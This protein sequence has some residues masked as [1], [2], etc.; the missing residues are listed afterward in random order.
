MRFRISVRSAV[1]QFLDAWNT[2]SIQRTP[3][4]CFIYIDC[5]TTPPIIARSLTDGAYIMDKKLASER[6]RALASND[7][8]RSKAARLRDVIDDVEAVLAAGVTRADVVAELGALGLEM[9]LATF[10][11]TLK[12]LRQ[13]R[14]K[15][16]SARTVPT[17]LAPTLHRQSHE[18]AATAGSSAAA[19]ASAGRSHDPADLDKII[20]DKPD[21]HALARL[22][23]RNKK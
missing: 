15:A 22:A 18:A 19:S 10:E 3:F 23:K 9:S 6:L 7:Q 11:T 16:L 20:G 21:L 5:F 13:K 2:P 14:G 8:N 1:G 4:Q 12:R 17:G